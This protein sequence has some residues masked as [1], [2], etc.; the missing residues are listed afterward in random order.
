MKLAY[1]PFLVVFFCFLSCEKDKLPTVLPRILEFSF[2]GTDVVSV[3]IDHELK[4]VKIILPY[5]SNVKG[6]APLIRFSSESEIIP[7]SGVEQDFSR[8][9]YYTLVTKKGLKVIY[10]VKLETEEQLS[11]VITSYEKDSV[12]A[13]TGVGVLGKYFGSF[14]SDIEA[15]LIGKAGDVQKIGHKLTDSSHIDLSIPLEVLPGQYI[16]KIKV[17]N[18]ETESRQKITVTYP[19]PQLVALSAVNLLTGD[20]LWVSGKFM[21]AKLY[22]FQLQL[23]DK[24]AETR[25]EMVKEKQGALGFIIPGKMNA[26][27][28]KVKM[29]NKSENKW[30]GNTLKVEL[31]DHQKPFVTGILNPVNSFKAGDTVDFTTVNFDKFPIRFYQVEIYS[32]SGSY[33]QNGLFDNTLRIAIP[34]NIK[35]GDYNLRFY[36]SNPSINYA[37]GFEIDKKLIVN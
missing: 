30:G 8:P 16:L 23:R 4:L 24:T 17:R 27:S 15:F 33:I 10:T 14:Q 6:L 12:E 7:A 20:T 9:V 32:E 2:P 34:T 25:L 29:Y 21:D 31:Y 1:I 36:L 22:A 11:P 19:S 37:Y 13:G 28:Y 35:K 3:Q 5:R 26:G 18:K